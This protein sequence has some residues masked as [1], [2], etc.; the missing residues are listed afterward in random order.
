MP[1]SNKSNRLFHELAADLKK[2]RPDSVNSVICP[3]CLSDFPLEAISKLSVEHVVSSKLQ[4]Q[5]KTLT[6]RTCNNS[7]GTRLD[8]HLVS[9]LK[10]ID[11]LEGT[12]P[13]ATVWRYPEGRVVGNTVLLAGTKDA[14]ITSRIVGPATNPAAIDGLLTELRDGSSINFTLNFDF[15]PEQYWKAAVRAAYLAVF[16]AQGYE[17]V[18]SEGARQARGVID[19]TTPVN[20]KIIM[21]AFPDA[22]PPKDILVMPHSFS[23]LGECFAVLLRLKTKRTRY[24]NVYLPGKPGCD[25]SVLATFYKYAS[26]L[27]IEITP[28]T[29][30]S[31]LHIYFGYDPVSEMRDGDALLKRFI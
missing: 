14:P 28:G 13:I 4:G 12:E 24:L 23:D 25:W 30:T 22:E 26:R 6:C 21:E 2:A 27:R 10:A 17:Y 31:P 7:Q 20:P 29:W 16:C 11:G 5:T 8:R 15:M 9:A 1:R 3:L 19:G 18:F